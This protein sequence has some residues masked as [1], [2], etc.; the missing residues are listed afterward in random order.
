MIKRVNEL[1]SYEARLICIRNKRCS[2]CPLNF[3]DEKK[4]YRDII[5]AKDEYEEKIK[6]GKI[7]EIKKE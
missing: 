3:D 4:C 6:F 1:T 7:M 5:Q 2:A